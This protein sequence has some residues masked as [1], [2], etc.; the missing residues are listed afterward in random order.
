MVHGDRIH[1][2][3]VLLNLLLNSLDAF[4]ESIKH[5]R[6]IIVQA[7]HV[8]E[9]MVELVVIDNG[10][11]ITQQQLHLLF[12][13]FFTTKPKGTGIGLA[14]SKTIV[15]SHGGTISARNRP[16]GGAIFSFTLKVAQ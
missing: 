4:D 5:D 6:K 3:Q 14:I 12:E 8:D 16:E 9:S 7:H 15:E 2:Q 13:P 10:K 11:G 1:L